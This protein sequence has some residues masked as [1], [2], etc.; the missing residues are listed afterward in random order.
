GP[1]PRYGIPK[2]QYA[3]DRRSPSLSWPEVGHELASLAM[4]E[5]V[6]EGAGQV[7]EV[8]VV[9]AA[10]E[11][12]VHVVVAMDRGGRPLGGQIDVAIEPV[13]RADAAQVGDAL[14]LAVRGRPFGHDGSEGGVAAA[15]VAEQVGRRRGWIY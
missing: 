14:R 12:H 15:Q 7:G 3:A 5:D 8:P 1:L 11:Q 13:R 9:P 2:L 10:V 6:A 4:D